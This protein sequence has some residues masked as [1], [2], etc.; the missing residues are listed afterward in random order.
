MKKL[1]VFVAATPFL[2]GCGDDSKSVSV[3]TNEAPGESSGS[4]VESSSSI[5][6]P[7]SSDAIVSSSSEAEEDKIS[8]GT[9]TDE[10]DGKI[11]KTVI[12]GEGESAQEWMAENLNYK[13]VNQFGSCYK[14]QDYYCEQ[15]GRLYP[16]ETAKKMCPEGWRPA[17]K[18]LNS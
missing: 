7:L 14:N 16:W 11:Y 2:V 18:T 15:Y 5:E 17:R 8:Y 4:L 1:F 10:R 12:V 6:E 3:E 9:L 13:E